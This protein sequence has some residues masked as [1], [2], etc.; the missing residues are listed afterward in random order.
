MLVDNDGVVFSKD[1]SVFFRQPST[2]KVESVQSDPG[3]GDACVKRYTKGKSMKIVPKIL[4]P[5]LLAGL[6]LQQSAIGQAYPNKPVRI[7][8][9]NGASGPPDMVLR[10][11]AQV[12]S[13]ALGQQF[14]VENRSGADGIIAFDSCAKARPDGYTLCQG[15]VSH[16]VLNPLM[17]AD[18]PYDILRDFV[19]V[20]HLGTT[21]N[22]IAVNSAVPVNSLREL[23][24]LAKANPGK[25]SW[26]S[27]GQSGPAHL[28]MAWLK[29][30]RG[31]SFLDVP[32][33]N[34]Q[35]A[36]MAMLA[37]D[38]QA[39]I[40]IPS[41]AAPA[42]K[43]GRAKVLGINGDVRS[44]I[45]PDVPLSGDADAEFGKVLITI[46]FGLLAPTGTP[47][48]IVNRLHAEITRG[49]LQNEAMREKFLGSQGVMVQSNAS[50]SP[51]AFGEFIRRE[52]EKLA[53]LVKVTGVKI[54]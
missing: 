9:A 28:Y 24:E 3:S 44:A 1:E 12:L 42:V 45:L 46:W 11:A 41:L 48:E 7:F 20:A 40:T 53:T 36:W 51:E 23:F 27:D 6:S 52:R 30:A 49:L 32:Y 43:A 10:G 35:V 25:I 13:L 31:I 2:Q 8:Q 17:R 54:E 15:A 34:A 39:S 14:I 47:K 29:N 16:I 50:A 5:V 18:M 22:S 26:G 21:H 38:I 33:K 37:G 4:L 19:P